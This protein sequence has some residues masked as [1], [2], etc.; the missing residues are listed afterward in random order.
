MIPVV[1]SPEADADLDRIW[2]DLGELSQLV[3]A[4]A[5]AK[6]A[7]ACLSLSEM[8]RRHPIEPAIR[9]GRTHRFTVDDFNIYYEVQDTLVE[10]VRILPGQMNLAR[11]F[12]R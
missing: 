1:F 10:I 8:P 4:R 6:L 2:A 5:T 9:G 12:K 3:A 7:E 11:F